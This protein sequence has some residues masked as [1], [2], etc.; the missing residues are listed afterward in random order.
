MA[1][2]DEKYNIKDDF[3]A[4]EK[5]VPKRDKPKVQRPTPDT[6]AVEITSDA[7][8]VSFDGTKLNLSHD[9]AIQKSTPPTVSDVPDEE[10]SPACPLIEKAYIYRWKN[11]YNYYEDFRRDARRYYRAS[12]REAVH[13]P[14]FSYV[15]QY[16]Q[17]TRDQLRWYIYWRGCVRRDVYPETDYSY[18]LLLITEI[19]NL[20]DEVDTVLGQR[21]LLALYRNY[22]TAYPRLCRYLSDWICDYSLI[23]HLPP[24]TDIDTSLTEN[25][26]L[27]E[28]YVFFEG[29][30]ASDN[31]AR[32]L[33]KYCSGYDY[34]K[35]KFAT[36]DNLE[37]YD[38][39]IS[40][41]LSRAIDRCS[42]PGSILSG[43]GL[44]SNLI[45]RDAY[46]GALC[47]SEIKRRIKV[48]FFSFSRSH[49]LRFLVADIIKHS[50]NKI[51]AYLGI[52]SRLSVFGIPESITHALDAYFAEE[53]PVIKR[54]PY[55]SE[56][57]VEDYDRLYEQ[58]HTELSL[59]NAEMI[60]KSSWNTTQLLVEAFDGDVIDEEKAQPE[61]VIEV[62]SN[63]QN[64]LKTALGDKYEFVLAALDEDI[65]QQ[66]AIAAR[67]GLLPDA[68]ADM[69]NDIAA[70]I[71][72]D[73]ILED[74][75]GGY[76][77]IEDYKEL[78]KN[79]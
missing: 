26:S 41:A 14:Y 22:S 46:S 52:K 2:S 30:D 28:F 71:L 49:E 68:L 79:E 47:S 64:D 55:E 74:A 61:P 67:L 17:L 43:A 70:D 36:N 66:K 38:R 19:I 4:I 27:R 20:A 58:P 40:G 11:N 78:F 23:H 16:V 9:V 32:L 8:S 57:A 69:I 62:K 53:L 56:S 44:D 18:I 24:P 72:G 54:M 48:K 6:S 50:E 29:N 21:I 45:T 59:E 73:I 15:P 63:D 7:P 75:V 25:C 34:K 77:I 3:W 31:Y 51:R 65:A 39:H 35:S 60:E 13:V 12:V 42:E 1:L 37:L 10:Y 33:I 5:L 76:T